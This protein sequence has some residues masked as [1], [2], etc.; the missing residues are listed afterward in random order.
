MKKILAIDFDGVL[1]QYSRGWLDGSIYDE[2]V[3]GA[4]E[5]MQRLKKAG[6]YLVIFT[7]RT[8]HSEVSLWLK[9]KLI[10]FDEITST[11][12]AALAY[13]DDR[14]VRFTNWTDITNYFD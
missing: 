9:E 10:P 12:I 4:K 7:T 5:A 14:A 2:P 8:N 13:I 11:K 3:A 1:H 6:Y